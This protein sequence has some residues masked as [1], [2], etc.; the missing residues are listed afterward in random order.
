MSPNELAQHNKTT[1]LLIDLDGTVWDA[2][3]LIHGADRAV[4]ALREAGVPFRFVTNTT[5]VPRDTIA[6]WL[7]DF[8]IPATADEVFTPPLA[9]AAWLKD[10]QIRRVFVCL[11]PHTFEEFP[12]FVVDEQAPEAVVIGD[13]GDSWTVEIMNTAF[14]RLLSGAEFVALHRNRYWKTGRG[15]CLDA[16]AF[17]AA[18]EYAT[19]R[20]ATLVGKPSRPLFEAAARSMDLSPGDVVMV[21]DSLNTDIAGAKAAGS[22]AILV[23]TGNY[24]EEQLRR[25]LVQ[26]DLVLD[27]LAAVPEALWPQEERK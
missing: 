24:D 25:S 6:R 27:S 17:V 23:R 12:D 2:D 11:P 15:L 9:A 3:A 26:P 19:G 13:M 10:R 4:K 14:R 20:T 16:G 1:G 18:L 7:A 5:R 21:G 22:R 8:G